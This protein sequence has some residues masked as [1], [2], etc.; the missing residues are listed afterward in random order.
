[1]LWRMVC[2]LKKMDATLLLTERCKINM[3]SLWKSKK[4]KHYENTA[5]NLIFRGCGPFGIF[6]FVNRN[7]Y[8]HIRIH[9]W[10]TVIPIPLGA[11][12]EGI[13]I[14]RVSRSNIPIG[15]Y[16][17]SYLQWLLQRWSR[18]PHCTWS[19]SRYFTQ[20]FGHKSIH[21]RR[22]AIQKKKKPTSVSLTF[23]IWTW[24]YPYFGRLNGRTGNWADWGHG[25]FQGFRIDPTTEPSPPPI[26]SGGLI[27]HLSFLTGNGF[28]LSGLRLGLRLDRTRSLDLLVRLGLLSPGGF[29][30]TIKRLECHFWSNTQSELMAYSLSSGLSMVFKWLIYEWNTQGWL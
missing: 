13:R 16:W 24:S 25:L 8:V 19:R 23:K 14:I 7:R 20:I 10:I 30:S 12:V 17:Y 18:R 9:V 27:L 29:H 5:R 28:D 22:L 4:V 2:R 6:C 3:A 1:M 11:L 21:F 15:V 26:Q